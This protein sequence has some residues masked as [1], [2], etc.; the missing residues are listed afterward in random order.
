MALALSKWE[1]R[2]EVS[3]WEDYHFIPGTLSEE[4]STLL[5]YSSEACKPP[6]NISYHSNWVLQSTDEQ[7]NRWS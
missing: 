4:C 2:A 7:R 6:Y 5:R 3:D 1:V